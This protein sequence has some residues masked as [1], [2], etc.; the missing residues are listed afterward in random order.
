MRKPLTPGFDYRILLDSEDR[1]KFGIFKWKV[2]NEGYGIRN[3]FVGGK[4]VSKLLHREVMGLSPYDKI[5]VD[6]L[7]GNRAD[8]RKCNLRL[9]DNSINQQNRKDQQCNNKSGF[10]N[11]HFAV[12]K[13]KW[14]ARVTVNGIKSH[15]GY[16]ESAAEAGAVALE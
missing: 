12:T 8:N 4:N 14:R 10:R 6:H 2:N 5:Q 7:N 13:G 1:A 16:Y 15:L 11:V 3:L 9:A